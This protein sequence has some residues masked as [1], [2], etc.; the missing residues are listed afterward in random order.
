MRKL[1][2]KRFGLS[3]DKTGVMLVTVIFIVAMALVFVTTAMMITI[4]ARQRIY[5]NAKY[6]Q[7][8]LTCTSLAQAIWQAIYSQQINDSMLISLANG[9]SGSGSVVNFSTDSVPGMGSGDSEA[10]AYFFVQQAE[11]KAAN[12]PL[13]I[14]I[15][16]KC[17]I[18]GNTQYYTMYLQKHDPEG[19]PAAMFDIGIDLGDGGKLV[20]GVFG[21]DTSLFGSSWNDQVSWRPEN[22]GLDPTADDNIVFLH[23]PTYSDQGNMGFYATTLTDGYLSFRDGVFARDVYFLGPH[24]GLD[25][26]RLQQLSAASQYTG[27]GTNGDPQY[28]N[29]YFYGSRA[30]IAT[31]APLDRATLESADPS[32]YAFSGNLNGQLELNGINNI[33][34]DLMEDDEGNLVGFDH[35]NVEFTGQSFNHFSSVTGTIHYEDGITGFSNSSSRASVPEAE[36][37]GPV[38]ANG[39]A[40]YMTRNPET[41]DTIDE[42]AAKWGSQETGAT[43][44][45]LT[46]TSLVEAGSYKISSA[47]NLTGGGTITFDVSA[48]D[49]YVFVDSATI[50]MSGGTYIEIKSSIDT[51]NAVYFFLKNGATIEVGQNGGIVDLRCFNDSYTTFSPSTIDQ[52]KDK[53]P[54]CFIFSMYTG[55]H[56]KYPVNFTGNNNRLLTAYLGFFPQSNPDNSGES[57]WIHINNCNADTVFYGR[58]CAGGVETD[59]TGNYFFIPY[60]PAP[61]LATGY[62]EYAYRD[63]T[64]FS[65]VALEDTPSGY[66]T[67]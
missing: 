13:I 14:G 21:F 2:K 59:N 49:I 6:D 61:P 48:G 4:A 29:L 65:V 42:V 15:E 43:E 56:S 20:K 26:G 7:A 50:T 17:S 9:S 58:V 30:P 27:G 63:N 35:F 54:R 64:D 37:W 12:K 22:H 40:S 31:N 24:S 5:E 10:S 32:T 28:G 66:F 36:G 55:G 60:C 39:M 46:S 62:R 33:N 18:D 23:N 34:L 16:V 8:K 47:Q 45:N 3:I 38:I 19:K 57:C 1:S 44:L 11:D 53:T 67:A 41:I 25:E 52:S 51:D